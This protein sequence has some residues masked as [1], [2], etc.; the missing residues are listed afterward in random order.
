MDPWP[1]AAVNQDHRQ[2]NDDWNHL[3]P[4]ATPSF[5]P[6]TAGDSKPAPGL[7]SPPCRFP[8]PRTKEISPDMA[9]RGGEEGMK[10]TKEAELQGPQVSPS[11]LKSQCGTR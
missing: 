10:D 6:W 1:N 2:T 8:D 7:G 11:G 9:E 5:H 4:F 3:H